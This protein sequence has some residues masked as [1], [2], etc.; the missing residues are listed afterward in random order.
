MK[1]SNK[2][3]IVVVLSM[4]F[5]CCN[6]A[7]SSDFQ[8]RIEPVTIRGLLGIQSGVV[9][10]AEGK[11]LI[12]GGR[13]DGLHRRQPWA[14][15]REEGRNKQL[16]VVD[17]LAG[18]VWMAS[19]DSLPVPVREQLCATNLEFHQE[20]DFLYVIGGYGYSESA[21]DHITHPCLTAIQVSPVVRAVLS[22]SPFREYFRQLRDERFAVTGGYLNKIYNAWYLTGGQRFDGR[23]NPMNHPTFVQQYTNSIHKFKIADD[24]VHLSVTTLAT[25]TDSVNLHR[26][27]FNVIPQIMPDGSEA[28]TAFSGVF[29][30]DADLPF[31]SCVNIDSTG[32]EVIGAFRQYY[33]HYHCANIPLYSVSRNEM[34]N[35]FFGGMA[36][37]T[38]SAGRLVQNDNV[39]FVKT[40]ARVTR[41]R[42]GHMTEYK[43]AE[44]MPG[45]LGSGAE[46]IPADNIPGFA[47]GVIMLDEL[48]TG[49]TLLGFIFGG[50][51]SSEAE[52]FWAN[53]GTQSAASGVL[54]KVYL[55]KDQK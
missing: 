14:T 41:D 54:Y 49:S 29:R 31:L 12:L 19:L 51:A 37:Y 23:Y 34:H 40:I 9:G 20:G 24:G 30:P 35:L 52:I 38:D 33:N 11:W 27:D 47:N 45:F 17:P 21:E 18:K 7:A 53:D 1:L 28:L 50:I 2:I 22:G 8:L 44:E 46:F 3:T 32:Y 6:Q 5:G 15:F 26:R 4:A 42:A 10:R 43:M 39:P 48:K 36:Q 16:M 13:T 55:V 25:F